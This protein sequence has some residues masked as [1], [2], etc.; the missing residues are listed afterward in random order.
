[1]LVSQ[2]LRARDGDGSAVGLVVESLRPRMAKMATYYARRTG[3]DPDDLL[4]E[5]WL[6]LL[7]SLPLVDMRIGTPE[8][9]LI[10]RARWRILDTIKRNRIRRCHPL[11]DLEMERCETGDS[12]DRAFVS[13]F[14]RGLKSSQREV[15]GCLM[16]GYTWR[17]TGA[18]LGCSSPNI[19]YHV[20]AIRKRYL[21]W[22]NG[23]RD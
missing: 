9:F 8:Q 21:E 2:I 22:E 6:A 7:E 23:V 13:E 10:Q 17:E 3:E 18:A 20:R 19:A 1:M 12:L 16:N 14:R 15:L 5:A 11:E 4:Q